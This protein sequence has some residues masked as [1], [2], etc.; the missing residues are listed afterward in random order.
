[1][2]YLKLGRSGL[3]VSRLCLGCM[4]FGV[5]ERGT[6]P[7]SLNE[8]DSRPL[9]KKAIEAGINFLA[10]PICTPTEPAKRF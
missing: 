10:P 4:G 2:E 8:E 7:W 1:M 9:I 6:I 3:E 5:P